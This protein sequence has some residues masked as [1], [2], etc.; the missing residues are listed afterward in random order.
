FHGHE[1][2]EEIVHAARMQAE[3]PAELRA[4]DLALAQL[5]ED[6]E[7]HGGEEN[8]GGPEAKG[9]LQNL[10]RVHRRACAGHGSHLAAREK[11]ARLA[12]GWT[13][14]VRRGWEIDQRLGLVR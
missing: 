13:R 8:L 3:F 10:G 5:G 2:V 1:R 11:S 7:F 6:A 12:R 4:S 9:C 14:G